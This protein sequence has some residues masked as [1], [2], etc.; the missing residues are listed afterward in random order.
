MLDLKLI[1]EQPDAVQRGLATRG[2][3]ELVPE[4]LAA[5]ADRR[6]LVTEAET[7]KAER[8]RTSEA[9]GQAKRRGENPEPVMARMRE[10]ADRIKAL[11]AEVKQV[12][13]RM[14]QLLVELP[15]LPHPS[16][17]V[18]ETEDDN[19]ETA[20]W[21]EPRR[22]AFEPKTHD[23]LGEALGILDFARAV[24]LAKSRFTVMWG[25][26]ARLER[27]LVPAHAGPPHGR[28]RLHRGL[29]AAARERVHH[30]PH[31]P[32]PEVRGAALQDAGAGREPA[33]ST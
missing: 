23:V 30:A 2:G 28:A 14:E 18:G 25:A 32:A 21:G 1:R 26:A 13:E 12:D 4:I 9:I 3:A 5:D 27:A 19:V 11:D 8:N 22:F 20:R 33:R 29:G 10:V 16:V 7:L 24:K 31:G 17:P 15:N 6:R